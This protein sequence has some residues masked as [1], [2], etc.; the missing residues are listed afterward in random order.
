MASNNW[1]AVYP[2]KSSAAI[3][4]LSELKNRQTVHVNS[5]ILNSRTVNRPILRELVQ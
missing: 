3:G 2:A 5:G 1:Q 4:G